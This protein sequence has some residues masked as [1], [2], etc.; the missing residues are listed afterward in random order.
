MEYYRDSALLFAIVCNFIGL[1]WGLLFLRTMK[2]LYLL[3]F[4]CFLFVVT[5]SCFEQQPNTLLLMADNLLE[6]KNV[7]PDS[8]EKD[9]GEYFESKSPPMGWNS[10]NYFGKKAINEQIVREVID[11][12][13]EEGLKDAGYEY[14]V[15]DGGWR[16]TK[17]GANHELLPHPEKFPNGI[18]VLADYAH[19][20]GL[21]LGLHTVPGHRD[22]GGDQVGAFGHEEV[23]IQ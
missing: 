11:A 14:I 2:N 7:Y 18:K 13:V 8:L 20:K 10:W 6:N 1:E 5:A 19:S 17:L 15:I 16:D 21:K 22:C 3:I 23:H 12:F 4:S 9:Q